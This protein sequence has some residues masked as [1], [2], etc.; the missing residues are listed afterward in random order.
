[1]TVDWHTLIRLRER[2]RQAAQETVSRERRSAEQHERSLQ[3]A[4]H[5]LQQRIDAK[6]SLWRELAAGEREAPA[7][8]PDRLRQASAWSRVLARQIAEAAQAAMESRAARDRQQACL[9]ESRRL[10]R[11]AAGDLEKAEQMCRREEAASARLREMRAE[12]RSEEAA[13]QRW[14]SRDAASR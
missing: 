14:A 13:L 12:D 11:A 7:L 6:D 2:H 9:Q 3:A 8:D 10:L 1:M 5:H 4:N